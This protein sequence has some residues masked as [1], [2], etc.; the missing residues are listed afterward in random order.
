MG[1]IGERR[2]FVKGR[3]FKGIAVN[4]V[5]V[6]DLPFLCKGL[7]KT[8]LHIAKADRCAMEGRNFTG[9]VQ[10]YFEVGVLWIHFQRVLR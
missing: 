6:A 4:G 3:S 8:L 7:E 9:R 1:K 2:P 10:N 5:T